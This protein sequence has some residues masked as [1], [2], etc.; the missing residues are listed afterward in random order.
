MQRL[1][2]KVAV[3]YGNETVGTTVA[4]AFA[5]EGAQVYLAGRTLT[6]LEV[7]AL[8]VLSGGGLIETAQVDALNEEVVEKHMNE[9]IRKSGKVDISFNAI[10]LPQTGP[11]ARH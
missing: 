7:V 4:K 9:I 3:I 6:K 8:E 5:K 11:R 10:G 1:E 2:K